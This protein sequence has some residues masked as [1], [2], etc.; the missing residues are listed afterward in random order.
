MQQVDSLTVS[1]LVDN[2]TDMLSSRP[3]HVASEA[4]VLLGA[5][6]TELTG[7]GLCSAHHGLSL[8]IAAETGGRA[9]TV[10]FDA[11]PDPYAIERNAARMG[12]ALGEVEAVVLSHGHFDHSEGLV[13][14]AELVRSAG[15]PQSIPLH[16][17]PDVFTLRANMLTGGTPIPL[18]EVPS[19]E[20]LGGA[21]YDVIRSSDIEDILDGAFFLSGEV[22]RKSF[23]R[24]L[25]NQVRLTPSGEWEPD[26]LVMDE[27]FLLAHVREKG[28]VVVTGCSHAGVV[29]VCRHARELFPDTPFYALIGGLHLVHPNEDLIDATIDGLTEFDFDVIVPGHCTGWR[30]TQAFVQAFGTE[31]VDPMAVGSRISL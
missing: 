28:L 29:N 23:E 26:P 20:A 16:L 25:Q 8:L 17:H 19:A 31:V 6:M 27:R 3:S 13:K 7:Q 2:T 15:G 12:L 1:V 5:G 24:G 11:G 18:Q 30:A 10:L 14:V 4:R 21:G 22:P 9:R